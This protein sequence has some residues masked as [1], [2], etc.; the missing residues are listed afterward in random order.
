MIILIISIIII[1]IIVISIIIIIITTFFAGRAPRQGERA[2][3]VARRPKPYSTAASLTVG[4]IRVLVDAVRPVTQA[5]RKGPQPLE[6]VR[7]EGVR[8]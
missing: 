1:I 2:S 4:I 5:S 8:E 7:R 3:S 6:R